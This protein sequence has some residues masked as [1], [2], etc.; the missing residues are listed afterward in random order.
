MWK[1]ELFT[2]KQVYFKRNQVRMDINKKIISKYT[3]NISE[4]WSVGDSVI[5]NTLY[6]INLGDWISWYLSE[7]NNVDAIEIDVINYLN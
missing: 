7:M 5:E 6:H 1:T 3:S 4:L 2:S